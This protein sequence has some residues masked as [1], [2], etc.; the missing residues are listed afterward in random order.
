MVPIIRVACTSSVMLTPDE[1]NRE[2]I[3]SQKPTT[4]MAQATA[5]AKEK[6]NPIDPPNA[7]PS[8]LDII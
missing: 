1:R 8:D 6:I 3:D 2:I 4:Y 7:G 5:F